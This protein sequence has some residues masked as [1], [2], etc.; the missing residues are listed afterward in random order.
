MIDIGANLSNPTFEHDLAD[1]LQRAK[2]AKLQGIIVTGTS[3]ESSLAALALAEQQPNFLYATAGVHPHDADSYNDN[4]ETQLI[5]M[6][7]KPNI[8]AVG[9][10]GLDFNRNFSTPDNQRQ[11]F[12]A[13][14]ALANRYQKPLFLHERDAFKDF[15]AIMAANK[16]EQTQAVVHCFTGSETALKAYLDLGLYIGITG[17]ISDKKRGVNLRE[18][19][20]YAPLDRLMIETDAPYLTPQQAGL[21]SQ[22]SKKN[23][24]EPWTLPYTAATLA[25]CLGVETTMLIEK[26]TENTNNFFNLVS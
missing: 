18:I 6:L 8:V 15:Y 11:A 17:W 21:K 16:K 3:V 12:E 4:I 19:I 23:R 14:I 22:L 24:N 25:E 20:K 5:A 2:D 13:Q 10:T 9:E 1:V 7:D 26:T